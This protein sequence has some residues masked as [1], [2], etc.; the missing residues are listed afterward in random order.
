MKDAYVEN[1]KSQLDQWEKGVEDLKNQAE[2]KASTATFL[3][4]WKA[5]RDAAMQRLE[6]LRAESSDRFDVLKMGVESAWEELKTAFETA[7]SSEP[8]NKTG[9]DRNKAA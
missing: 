8:V 3:E 6:E 2:Q 5:K 9:E 7:T 1:K 4:Q